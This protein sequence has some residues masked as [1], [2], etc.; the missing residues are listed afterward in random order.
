MSYF[1]MVELCFRALKNDIYKNLYS[2]R[3]EV[4]RDILYLLKSEKIKK[5]LPYLYKETLNQYI[6]FM[7]DNFYYNLNLN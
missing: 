4:E 1:N 2:S 6:K 3:E 5:Q 7:K